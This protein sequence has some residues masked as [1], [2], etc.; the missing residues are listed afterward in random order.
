MHVF[1]CPLYGMLSLRLDEGVDSL[2]LDLQEVVKPPHRNGGSRDQ[3]G[4]PWKREQHMFLP[5]EPSL[6]S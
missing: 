4:V 5:T 2:E 1:L 6:W 3:T